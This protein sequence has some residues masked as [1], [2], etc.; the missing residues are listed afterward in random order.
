MRMRI[1]KVNKKGTHI[2]RG[3]GYGAACAQKPGVWDGLAPIFL[4]KGCWISPLK[5]R[6]HVLNPSA[7]K[8]CSLRTAPAE[9]IWPRMEGSK[10]NWQRVNRQRGEWG[11]YLSS[12]FLFPTSLTRDPVHRLLMVKEA[13]ESELFFMT[14]YQVLTCPQQWF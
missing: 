13:T 2:D 9:R 10:R 8:G 5:Y 7:T 6:T 4:G 12:R 14:A 11:G 3:E 1:L